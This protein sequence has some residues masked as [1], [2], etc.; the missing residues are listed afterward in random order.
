[1][2][3]KCSRKKTASSWIKGFI[4]WFAAVKGFIELIKALK[5]LF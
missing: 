3:S 2:K 5:S 1:M 4:Q